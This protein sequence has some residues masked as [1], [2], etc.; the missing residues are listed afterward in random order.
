MAGVGYASATTRVFAVIG[1]PVRHSLSPA[2]HAAAIRA[3]GIDAT[4]VAFEVAAGSAVEAIRGATALGLAGLSVT[5]PHKQSVIAALDALDPVAARLDAV[6][7]VSFAGP[8]HERVARGHNTDGDGFVDALQHELAIHPADHRV[9]VL[10]AGGA[11]RSVVLALAEAGANEVIVVNRN[12]ERAEQAAELAGPRGRVGSVD[13]VSGADVVVNATSV[14]L[15]TAEGNRNGPLPL[16]PAWLHSGQVVAD[17]IYH[18]AATP[19]LLAAAERGCRVMNGL[20]M[21]AHQAARQFTIWT[22]FVPPVTEML[23]AARA[24]LAVRAHDAG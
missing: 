1:D 22:G 11:A 3:S 21:L 24:E 6:N 13:D 8:V 18:P 9:A 14:G 17:L 5:M 2:L 19:L 10:G 7:C 15:G 23:A 12:H 16:D 20:G 4:Y